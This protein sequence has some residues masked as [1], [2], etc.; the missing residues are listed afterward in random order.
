MNRRRFLIALAG[1]S[2]AFPQL[3]YADYVDSVVAQLEGQGYWDI[4][5]TRTLLGRTRILATNDRGV[6][7]LVLNPR[8]GELL[9]DAWTTE[10]GE[11]IPH[12]IMEGGGSSSSTGSSGS[13]HGGD[14]DNDDDDN[15]GDDR[16]GDDE[17]D[18]HGGRDDD[19]NDD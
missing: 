2:V 15:D 5:V 19:D 13:G 4:E 8:T 16:G 11:A 14:D 3:A 17:S 7:E 6:R 18:D 1:W 10:E 12:T 9:R